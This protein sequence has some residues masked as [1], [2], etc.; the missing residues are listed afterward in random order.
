MSAKIKLASVA[1]AAL[2][3]V[4]CGGSGNGSNDPQTNKPQTDTP[5]DSNTT[6]GDSKTGDNSGNGNNGSNPG[7]GGTT[8]GG[9]T[10][11]GG[12]TTPPTE[13]EKP[14]LLF[15]ATTDINTGAEPWITDGSPASTTQL[16]DI[17]E[18]GSSGSSNF[19]QVGKQWF[20]VA[21]DNTH[22]RELWITDGTSA[23][24]KMVKDIRISGSSN[25]AQ[26][27][28]L[29]NKLM[30]VAND[31]IN[32]AELW[33]SDGT[34]AGTNMVK[35]IR[36]GTSSPGIR[37]LTSF[38]NKVYFA[39]RDNTSLGNELWES[40][41]TAA[42]TK[43]TQR[44][45]GGKVPGLN[46]FEGSIP[47]QLKVSNGR[48]YFTAKN[49]TRTSRSQPV[50]LEP[51]SVLANGT[52]SPLGD[53]RG[54][55]FGS[56]PASYTEVNFS[57]GKATVFTADTG[58]GTEIWLH[59]NNN[60]TRLTN[61]SDRSARPNFLTAAGNKL[62]YAAATNP[63]GYELR[64]S[65]GS[66]GDSKLVKDI[67]PGT[68]GSYIRNLTTLGN[69]VLFVARKT[70]PQP[71]A[72][73]VAEERQ[74]TKERQAL[75]ASAITDSLWISDGTAAGTE[76][77]L[78]LTNGNSMKQFINLG[79]KILFSANN[80]TNGQ[81]LWITDGSK[82]GTRLLKDIRTGSD[83][84]NPVFIQNALNQPEA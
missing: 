14:Q 37:E 29:N 81:E 75:A 6:P 34:A 9:T 17:N 32:G 30:F 19:T 18:A 71:A 43:I 13:P 53:L 54:G 50:N 65:E 61:F 44:I 66:A 76:E 11:P 25:P 36:S 5:T 31:G 83:S 2:M 20:F 80:G 79:D 77:I 15:S 8:G 4:A 68:S 69:K 58:T 23:G 56:M 38:S 72:R 84:S 27:V 46:Q 48:L 67:A 82:A 62:F 74:V 70:N 26:L 59:R 57:S 60:K 24:T 78:T 12:G 39:A 55:F 49:N 10:T 35:D 73:P 1:V 7:N 3:T 64:V 45:S 41:G 16:K 22:G 47:S 63:H 33:S 52:V 21:S 40:D 42:G 51:Y 28:A